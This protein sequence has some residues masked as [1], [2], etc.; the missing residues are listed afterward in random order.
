MTGTKSRVRAREVH[1]GP[2]RIGAVREPAVLEPVVK[3][4]RAARLA[5]NMRALVPLEYPTRSTERTQSLQRV[6]VDERDEYLC[7]RLGPPNADASY[8]VVSTLARC[9]APPAVGT[10]GALNYIQLYLLPR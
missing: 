10:R 2:R 9:H 3:H 5:C 4:E 1:H 8:W 7:S 6:G